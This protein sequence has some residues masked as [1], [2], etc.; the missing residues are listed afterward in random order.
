MPLSAKVAYLGVACSEP[1]FYLEEG[2]P[3]KL[4]WGAYLAFFGWLILNWNQGKILEKLS[5]F[6]QVLGQL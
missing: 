1:L 4:V 2:H 3:M 5:T 6:N